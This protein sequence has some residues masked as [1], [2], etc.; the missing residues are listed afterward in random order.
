MLYIKRRNIS[1]LKLT[2]MSLSFVLSLACESSKESEE[3]VAGEMTAGEMTAGAMTAGAMTAGAMTAGAMTAGEMTA[4]AMTAGAMTAGEMTA[5][6]E[7]MCIDA[8]QCPVPP[9]I[10]LVEC[11]DQWVVE[12]VFTPICVDGLCDMERSTRQ[13]RDCSAEN[14]ICRDGECLAPPPPQP[15]SQTEPC[16]DDELCVYP[17]GLCGAVGFSEGQGQ[18]QSKNEACD[19]LDDPVCGCDG[20][21]YSNACV[22]R[23]QGIDVS[24]FGGCSLEAEM[25]TFACGEQSCG[26]QTY[27]AI[28]MNDVIGPDQ[29]E[30]TADCVGLPAACTD[31]GELS[32]TTCFEPDLFMTCLDI[33]EQII[34]VYPGG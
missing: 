34:V 30:Y 1:A 32:C 13:Q 20:Q 11:E 15:C 7:P 8:S 5:G 22:A 16:A 26:P 21:R 19:F 14:R 29:L 25:D 23:T 6:E 10:A 4:G 18:C 24:Q 12:V 28:F 9:P 33:G 31:N 27:C 3:A 2:L 17:E